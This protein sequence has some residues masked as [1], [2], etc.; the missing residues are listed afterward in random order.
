VKQIEIPG[1]VDLQVNGFGGVDF[2]SP[3]LTEEQVID[4]CGA[5]ARKGTAAFL[6]TLLSGPLELYER[7]L[8]LLASIMERHEAGHH[9]PGLHLEG[10]FISPEEGARGVHEPRFIRLPD[11]GFFDELYELARGRIRILT[12]AAE[13]P[14]AD[15]L[16]RHAS[17]RGVVVSLGHQ[18]AGADDLERLRDAGAVLLTHV[19]NGIPLSIHRHHNPL[20]AALAADE[21][22]VM[23][24]TDGHHLPEALTRVILRCREPEDLIVVSDSSPIAGLAPGRHRWGTVQAVLEENG[25]LH[26]EDGPYLAGSSA[27]MLDCMNHLASFGLLSAEE[28]LKTGYF[29]P[30]RILD[31]G[32]PLYGERFTLRFD[33]KGNMFRVS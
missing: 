6:P 24:I 2:S 9:M 11:I 23:L 32:A 17:E 33:E 13:L 10:P 1:F 3:E 4:V 8:P 28:L 15:R 22:A 18:L 26:V 25:Y 30:L 7:N 27:T 20:W 29:N 14:G 16:A 19:G 31:E 12:I 21:L 5:L